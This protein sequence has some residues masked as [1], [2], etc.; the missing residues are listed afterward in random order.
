MLC[1]ITPTLQHQIIGALNT[2]HHR[3]GFFTVREGEGGLMILVQ[4]TLYVCAGISASFA[5]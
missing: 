1:V 5:S 4:S 2:A 3:R